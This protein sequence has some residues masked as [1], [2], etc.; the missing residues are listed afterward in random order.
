[1]RAA[2]TTTGIMT[3]TSFATMIAIMV[4]IMTEILI[5]ATTTMIIAGK[6]FRAN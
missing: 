2:M 4:G 6:K 5:A 1:M 3:V